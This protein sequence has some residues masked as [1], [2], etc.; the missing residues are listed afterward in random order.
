MA[1]GQN[2]CKAINEIEISSSMIEAGMEVLANLQG[3]VGSSYLVERIFEVM[4][5]SA[6]GDFLKFDEDIL[7]K[8]NDRA[9][10]KAIQFG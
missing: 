3:E 6:N 7:S 1:K 2:S 4:L 9:F 8:H 5:D 10:V